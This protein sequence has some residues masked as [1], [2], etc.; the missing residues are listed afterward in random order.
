MASARAGGGGGP[1]GRGTIGVA[2]GTR[3]TYGPLQ[4]KLPPPH[5]R[6]R[7]LPDVD[8]IFV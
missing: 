5:T 8:L 3:S 7:K 6:T 2:G 1:K 4:R